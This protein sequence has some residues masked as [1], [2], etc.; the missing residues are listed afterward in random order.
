MGRGLA[1]VVCAALAAMLGGCTELV[2]RQSVA[3]LKDDMAKPAASLSAPTRPEPPLRTETIKPELAR[4][5]TFRADGSLVDR[6]RAEQAARCGQRHIDHGA[7]TLQETENEKQ[8]AD[9]IC[10]ELHKY[11]HVR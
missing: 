10:V 3:S 8:L 7:G 11:D 6:A 2:R 9:A 5:E 4:P 1:I